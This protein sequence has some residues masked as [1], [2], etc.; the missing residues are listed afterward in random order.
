[1]YILQTLRAHRC[2]V[3]WCDVHNYYHEIAS[4][5][6]SVIV[7]VR[8]Y[9]C[10]SPVYSQSPLPPP[11]PSLILYETATNRKPTPRH[12]IILPKLEPQWLDSL[13][14]IHQCAWAKTTK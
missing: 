11:L 7:T 3:V 9:K 2:G 5:N 1:M 13:S 8:T 12:L 14:P 4:R 10:R 6:L